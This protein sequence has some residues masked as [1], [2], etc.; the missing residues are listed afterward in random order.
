MDDSFDAKSSHLPAHLIE[1]AIPT[2]IDM[3]PSTG[4]LAVQKLDLRFFTLSEDNPQ[5]KNF[6]QNLSFFLRQCIQLK[7]LSVGICNGKCRDATVRFIVG[8]LVEARLKM[9]TTLSVE[10]TLQ[11]IPLAWLLNCIRLVTEDIDTKTDSM[12]AVRF[13][14]DQQELQRQQEQEYR[15]RGWRMLKLYSHTALGSL[16]SAVLGSHFPTL[17]SLDAVKCYSCPS[18]VLATLLTSSPGLE[19]LTTIG[20]R[21]G[22]SDD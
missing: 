12:G 2:G 15:Q 3:F 16:S 1:S 19:T 18:Q 8:Y 13:Q 10:E 21:K 9:L 6:L 22:G 4:P 14:G 7:E 11:D 5:S 20:D 17:K